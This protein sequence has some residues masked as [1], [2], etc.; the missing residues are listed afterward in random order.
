[1]KNP[2]SLLTAAF[3]TLSALACILLGGCA[4]PDRTPPS[5]AERI[6]VPRYLGRWYEIARLPMPFQRSNEAAIAEYG[7]NPD[8][9]LSV[10]NIAIRPNGKSHDIHGYAKIL[11]P[12]ENTKL[13]VRFS[14][15]FGPFIPVSKEGNYWILYIDKDY[16]QAIVGTPDYKYLWILSRTQKVSEAELLDLETIARKLGFDLS[17]LIRDPQP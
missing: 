13:A 2:R 11:N 12:P 1:V 6:D 15:W 14:T 5:T 4:A 17:G 7:V 9:T 3:V 16:R 10:H 8:K